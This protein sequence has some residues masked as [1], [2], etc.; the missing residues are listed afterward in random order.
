M[1]NWEEKSITLNTQYMFS[2]GA[3]KYE[4]PKKVFTPEA[5]QVEVFEEVRPLVN[6]FISMPGRNVMLLAYGQTGTGKTHTIFGPK[7]AQLD[8]AQEDD[9]GI[10][11][12]VVQTTLNTM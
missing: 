1:T 12:K 10:F 11:P 3:N 7:E 8:S 2:K 6:E 4:F 5:T 9:W